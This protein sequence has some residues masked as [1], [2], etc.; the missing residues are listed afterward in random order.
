MYRVGKNLWWGRSSAVANLS[1]KKQ[2]SALYTTNPTSCGLHSVTQR[3]PGCSTLYYKQLAQ[4][5]TSSHSKTRYLLGWD[6]MMYFINTSW[7][8]PHPPTVIEGEKTRT[9]FSARS[10]QQKACDQA[11]NS[12][13]PVWNNCCGGSQLLYP[14]RC[15]NLK[16]INKCSFVRR[17]VPSWWKI[18]MDCS[19]R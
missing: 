5:F 19:E 1:A 14:K 6:L 3:I 11:S 13:E 15:Q 9:I 4:E 17:E 7:K 8:K 12:I 16:V 10:L 2:D 18:R